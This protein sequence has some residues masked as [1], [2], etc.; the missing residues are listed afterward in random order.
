MAV[1]TIWELLNL[2]PASLF[3]RF[4]WTMN[5]HADFFL[6]YNVHILLYVYYFMMLTSFA[7]ALT[8]LV[9]GDLNVIQPGNCRCHLSSQAF[10]ALTLLV[11]CQEGHPA[12]KNLTDE[13]L[14]W[15][16]SAAKCK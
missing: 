4:L 15:L 13:V 12:R 5:R 16:S 8:V 11:G 3:S 9:V 6:P 10:S 14:L 1:A 7:S 2:L